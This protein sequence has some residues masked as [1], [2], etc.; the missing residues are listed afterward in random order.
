[1]ITIIAAI[2]EKD[3]AIGKNNGLL[4]HLPEDLAHFK[5]LTAGHPVIMGRKTYDSL[6]P[7]FKPLPNRTNIVITNNSDLVFPEQVLVI[8]SLQK[9]V[10]CAKN[11]D[12]DIFIIG[13]GKIYE[14]AFNIGC[15]DRLELTI[16]KSEEEGTVFFPDWKKF[17]IVTKSTEDQVSKNGLTYKFI[18]MEK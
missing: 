7:K 17:G 6:P 3:N 1:M 18:T 11:I 14:E 13:G 12:E 2:Q 9:A 16:V 10:D 4:F 5:E 15:A 8:D